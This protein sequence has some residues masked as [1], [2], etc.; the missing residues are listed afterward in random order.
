MKPLLLLFSLLS[1][2]SM[3]DCCH[4]LPRYFH[5]QPS[6]HLYFSHITVSSLT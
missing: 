6:S 5:S 2:D 3:M 1:F 4:Y